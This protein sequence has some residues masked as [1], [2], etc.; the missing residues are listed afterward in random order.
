MLTNSVCSLPSLPS[1]LASPASFLERL[2]VRERKGEKQM[3]FWNKLF[4]RKCMFQKESGEIL[5]KKK[6]F[7][8]FLNKK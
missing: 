8:F 1:S 6:F 3:Q 2:R 4:V 5:A 7:L